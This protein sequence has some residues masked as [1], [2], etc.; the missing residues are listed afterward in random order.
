MFCA[1]RSR[2]LDRDI[3]LSIKINIIIRR[4]QIYGASCPEKTL[5]IFDS[6]KVVVNFSALKLLTW[7]TDIFRDDSNNVV[8]VLTRR[9][10][11]LNPWF[12]FTSTICLTRT[13]SNVDCKFVIA[14]DPTL[15]IESFASDHTSVLRINQ[16]FVTICEL[17]LIEIFT[18]KA[19][20][21][22]IGTRTSVPA[23]FVTWANYCTFKILN[24]NVV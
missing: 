19:V 1:L 15:C 21:T 5:Y 20:V 18:R 22:G 16:T 8:T 23:F 13:L 7:L 9:L 2:S 10:V 6:T 14:V 17:L 4:C 24:S 3:H 12:L 11:C